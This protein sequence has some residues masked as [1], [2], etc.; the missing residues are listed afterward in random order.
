M[1]EL[2]LIIRPLLFY[3][4]IPPP[5]VYYSFLIRLISSKIISIYFN[6]FN[7]Q[8]IILHRRFYNF[9][10]HFITPLSLFKFIYSL[11]VYYI[12]FS[13]ILYIYFTF[14]NFSNSWT[15]NLFFITVDDSIILF[16]TPSTPLPL[17]ELRLQNFC[18]NPPM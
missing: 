7:L 9:I 1:T 8:T 4:I 14:F 15:G 6:Y 5:P 16:L 18:V 11:E 2:F 10:L 13:Q 3:L 12:F 17:G